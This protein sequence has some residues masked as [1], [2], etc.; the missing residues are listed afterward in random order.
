VGEWLLVGL[1]D[2]LDFHVSNLS[3]TGWKNR[4]LL[5]LGHLLY[6]P[7][8]AAV[9]E[10]LLVG[11]LDDLDFHGSVLLVRVDEC[12]L[13]AR[14]LQRMCS[15]TTST[16]QGRSVPFFL[17]ASFMSLFMTALFRVTG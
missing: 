9:G 12:E 16:S 17:P 8:A 5:G 3:G 14:A 6:H 2:D 15:M 13:P 7:R 10:G 1:L 4:L 11:L